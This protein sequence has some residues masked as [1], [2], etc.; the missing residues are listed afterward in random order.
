MGTDV[1]LINMYEEISKSF[2][3]VFNIDYI[4]FALEQDEIKV[5]AHLY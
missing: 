2:P 3:R 1:Y 4:F 5:I